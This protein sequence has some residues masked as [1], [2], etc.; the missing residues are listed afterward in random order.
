MMTYNEFKEY[1]SEHILDY[2]PEEYRKGMVLIEKVY[3]N[4]DV[5]LDSIKIAGVED[6]KIMPV[7]YLNDSFE[8]YECGTS[9]DEISEKLANA[10]INSMTPKFEIDINNINSFDSIKDHVTCRL[11]NKDSNKERLA[12]MPHKIMAN[13]LAITYT[14]I[15]SRDKEG[16]ASINVTNDLMKYLGTDV[17]TLHEA[18][19]GNIE[20]LYKPTVR[21]MA[22]VIKGLFMGDL[23]KDIGVSDDRAEEM[24]DD[25]VGDMQIP[26]Y[27]L[28]GANSVNGAACIA[29]PSVLENLSEKL[30]G[31]YFVIP[32]SVHEVIIVPKNFG[33][34]PEELTQMVMDV[35]GSCVESQDILST[36]VY[37]YDS[38]TKTLTS[39]IMKSLEENM[40]EKSIGYEPANAKEEIKEQRSVVRGKSL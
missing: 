1:I 28:S 13:D 22:D 4:N 6:K 37:E 21:S 15:I 9:L 20:K 7:L 29:S 11:C 40:D 32:S 23:V 39:S 31:D 27:V 36:H 2:F 33:M 30:G 3:K 35:N 5:I 10:Y 38:K 12:Y 26:M 25:M 8:L 19:V 16:T 14:I 24:L 18:A 34:E 17:E